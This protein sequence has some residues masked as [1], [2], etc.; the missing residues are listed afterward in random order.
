MS[1]IQKKIC[2]VGDFHVGKTSLI[3]R[4]VDRQFSD[5]YLSTVGVKI[6]R[7]LIEIKPE[8]QSQ[9]KQSQ[10]VQ[11]IIWDLEGQ[12]K[13]QSITPSYLQGAKGAII[14]GD[15]TRPETIEHVKDHI[16]L[17]FSVNPKNSS[18]IVAL[19][20]ADL[21]EETQK[22]ELNKLQLINTFKENIGVIDIYMT[23]A[24]IGDKVDESFS[25][26]AEAML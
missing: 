18:V 24:K 12:T 9:N 2:L 23:S 10:Q 19:N 11:L 3:R 25:K 7:K 5:K 8:N 16:E 17:F 14:V 21:L 1:I 13:F 22:D 4:F 15:V 6:S 20:K 26:L